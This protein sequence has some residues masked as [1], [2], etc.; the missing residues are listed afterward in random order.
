M[1]T[2]KVES[3]CHEALKKLITCIL[4]LHLK[5]NFFL[6]FYRLINFGFWFWMA[7]YLLN[8]YAG[9][10]ATKDEYFWNLLYI[11]IWLLVIFVMQCVWSR[12]DYV[13]SIFLYLFCDITMW[14]FS[15]LSL[16]RSRSGSRHGGRD[17]RGRGSSREKRSSRKSS[18]PADNR[19][20]WKNMQ[21]LHW[22]F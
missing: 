5:K 8:F 14:N 19:W 7:I 3:G 13:V 9:E 16:V 20:N 6:Y 2:Q 1:S 18:S 11:C 15:S 17:S 4:I 21:H 22:C 12:A 10:L